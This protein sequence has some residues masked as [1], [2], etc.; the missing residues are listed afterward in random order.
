[1]TPKRIITSVIVL[2]FSFINGINIYGD[3]K[4]INLQHM[5]N[6]G[7]HLDF[8]SIDRPN[9]Y[10][11]VVNSVIIIEGGGAVDY[12]DVEIVSFSTNTIVFSAR[13]D[14]YY[15]T[16]DASILP[17]AKYLVIITAPN[18]NEFLDFLAINHNTDISRKKR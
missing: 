2:M 6:Q 4:D 14:G 3:E 1:M 9:I 17:S 5:G 16:I 10:Y 8:I 18:G 7:D 15:D 12:Y 11:D 13:V